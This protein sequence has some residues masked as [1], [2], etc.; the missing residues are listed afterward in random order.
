MAGTDTTPQRA[1]SSGR[2]ENILTRKLGPLPGWAWGA[3][4]LLAVV[5]Y[6]RF[7]AG[8]KPAASSAPSTGTQS[9]LA[10]YE[11]GFESGQQASNPAPVTPVAPVTPPT[12]APPPSVYGRPFPPGRYPGGTTGGTELP[13]GGGG[14][15]TMEPHPP[16]TSTSTSTYTM[17]EGHQYRRV[18]PGAGTTLA[19]LA[20]R[21]YPTAPIMSAVGVLRHYNPRLGG[22]D[23]FTQDV[24]G[25]V[26]MIP[27]SS[28][29]PVAANEQ[30]AGHPT[31]G[32]T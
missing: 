24:G 6:E 23:P 22:I 11:S 2:G 32:L 10:A 4:A 27:E 20:H 25:D 8:A 16:S 5:L 9:I 17:S 26:L 1:P 12:A 14:L 7:H 28:A 31:G 29:S 15:G 18:V 21:I 19:A 30:V 13:G 3:I